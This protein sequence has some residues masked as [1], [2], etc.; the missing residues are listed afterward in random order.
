MVI[1]S[2]HRHG[3]LQQIARQIFAHSQITLIKN[4][5]QRNVAI[6]TP[7]RITIYNNSI[8]CGD[9]T[10][11]CLYS[12]CNARDEYTQHFLFLLRFL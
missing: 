7:Y 6:L 5:L 1:S 9:S 4:V 2:G 10:Q 11:R 8:T 12:N 3:L